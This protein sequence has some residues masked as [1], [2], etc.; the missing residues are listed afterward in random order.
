MDW[1][2]K[3][4][5][6]TVQWGNG[7]YLLYTDGFIYFKKWTDARDLLT[8]LAIIKLLKMFEEQSGDNGSI[9]AI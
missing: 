9:N 7:L 5:D 2:T 4:S 3:N 1:L 8:F 6:A